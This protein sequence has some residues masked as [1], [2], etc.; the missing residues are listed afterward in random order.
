M[1]L[2]RW[3]S[4]RTIPPRFDLRL[5][6][7]DLA[8]PDHASDEARRSPAL[9]RADHLEHESWQE[10]ADWLL[11]PQRALVLLTGVDDANERTRLLRLGF[12]DIVDS[13]VS[14]R[15]IEAR[16][17]RIAAQAKSLPRTRDIGLLRLDLFARDGFVAQRALGLHP[18]E[19][20]LIWR[21]A[22]SPGVV[23]S[24]KALVRDVWRLA[25]V[26]DTNSLAVHVFRLRAKLALA[27]HAGLVR[28]E[29][30]GGYYLNR[31]EPPAVFA[32][33]MLAESD[34]QEAKAMALSSEQIIPWE[35]KS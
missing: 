13:Q 24:K 30:S 28:T 11:Q 26:P 18:R 21:L 33:F 7:W 34:G 16:A 31:A 5:C 19:F 35:P 4:A 14:L 8:G 32:P 10:F 27:G 12:G 3:L 9:A 22:D 2:F 25:H 20:A 15:E 23:V 17:M 1:R 6:G 29:P